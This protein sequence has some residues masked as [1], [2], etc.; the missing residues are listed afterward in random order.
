MHTMHCIA[1]YR[2]S[3]LHQGHCVCH[4]PALIEPMVSSEYIRTCFLRPGQSNDLWWDSLCKFPDSVFMTMTM[5]MTN[6]D[7]VVEDDDCNMAC[8]SQAVKEMTVKCE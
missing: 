3:V 6:G 2:W 7:G 5:V 8:D 4:A 1:F